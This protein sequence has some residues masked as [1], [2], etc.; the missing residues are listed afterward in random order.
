MLIYARNLTF[1]SKS[2]NKALKMLIFGVDT[3]CSILSNCKKKIEKKSGIKIN[4]L[5]IL[6][7]YEFLMYFFVFLPFVFVV[8][9]GE[10][11]RRHFLKHNN[12][13]TN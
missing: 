11:C 13:K 1:C 10:I 12:A 8:F 9:S 4:F 5:Y 2:V 3:L 6:L 7:F